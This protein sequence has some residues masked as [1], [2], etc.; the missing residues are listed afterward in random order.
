[1]IHP[2]FVAWAWIKLFGFPWDPRFWVAFIGHD[3]GYLGKPNMDGPEGETHPEL[4]ATLVHWLCDWS[5]ERHSGRWWDPKAYRR[6]RTWYYFSLCHSRHYSKRVGLPI[7]RLAIA[8]KLAFCL[9]PGWLYLPRVRATGEL[10]E[11]MA[12]AAKYARARS[13]GVGNGSRE[14]IEGLASGDAV[15]WHKALCSRQMRFV[16]GSLQRRDT[17]MKVREDA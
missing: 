8:D 2:W 16:N 1:M 9:E 7:S 14:E 6:S 3:L 12:L 13:S 15:T 4:G 11:Y 10:G 17:G 5:W